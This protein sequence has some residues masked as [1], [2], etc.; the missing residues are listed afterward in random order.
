MPDDLA[1]AA[2]PK[3]RLERS[4]GAR[5]TFEKMATYAIHL[6]LFAEQIGQPASSSATSPRP[7]PISRSSTLRSASTTSS[8][9]ANGWGIMLTWEWGKRASNCPA[10]GSA[11]DVTK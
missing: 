6:E 5:L 9:A 3:C 1:A 7:S 11:V 4:V 10:W 2:L 8:T